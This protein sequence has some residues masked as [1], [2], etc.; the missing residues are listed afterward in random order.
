MIT[1]RLGIPGREYFVRIAEC[2][3]ND[4]KNVNS[5]LR[6]KSKLNH[7]SFLPREN[8]SEVCDFEKISVNRL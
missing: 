7:C 6:K 2:H 5:I 3:C 4:W 1:A 8:K